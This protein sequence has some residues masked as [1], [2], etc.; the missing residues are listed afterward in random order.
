MFCK[1]IFV[2]FRLYLR[3]DDFW[4]STRMVSK[5]LMFIRYYLLQLYCLC[6]NYNY[7]NDNDN[8]DDDNDNDK[9]DD[10]APFVG[11]LN[12]CEC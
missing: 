8:D 9:S 12:N 5:F 2:S 11:K 10:D 3:R 4:A 7:N 6:I 1:A